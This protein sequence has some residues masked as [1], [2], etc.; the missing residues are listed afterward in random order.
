MKKLF[1]A[2]AILL[3]ISITAHAQFFSYGIKGGVNS[4]KVSVDRI[5]L[6]NIQVSQDD[7]RDF[8]I[9]QGESKLGLHFG[10][11]ARLK[12]AMIYIQPELLFTQTRGE[13]VIKDITDAQDVT[14][15][16]A[17]QS[18]NKFDVPVMVGVKF[19]PARV[20]LGPVASFIINDKSE[21]N[22]FITTDV[23][24][25][26]NK[27]VFGY[28][29]GVGVDILKFATLDL[30]YEGNLSKLGDG[31]TIGGVERKFDQRNPQIILSLGI[32]F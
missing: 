5:V 3:S 4:S 7:I 1:L 17:K 22:K 19:G 18:F 27:A 13:F 16:I 21:L 2:F 15:N 20:G 31:V 14:A 32:F 24:N 26:F 6:E 10:A 8:A 12:V 28:Q 11:F 25:E 30:K 23:E 29:V 9:E